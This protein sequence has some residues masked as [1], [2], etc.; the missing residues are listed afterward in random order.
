MTL[1]DLLTEPVE[2]RFDIGSLHVL[3]NMAELRL[4]I[5]AAAARTEG[6]RLLVVIG[7]APSTADEVDEAQA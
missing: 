6:P 4:L 2:L 3:A 1:T 5:D 7:P